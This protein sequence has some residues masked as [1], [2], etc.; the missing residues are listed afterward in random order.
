MG[1]ESYEMGKG[2][3]AVEEY[4][5]IT[6]FLQALKQ[7]EHVLDGLVTNVEGERRLYRLGLM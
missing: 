4:I 3:L 6:R 2:E 5:V 7:A 1:I